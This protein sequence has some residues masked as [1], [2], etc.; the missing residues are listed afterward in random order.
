MVTW[1]IPGAHLIPLHSMALLQ[2]SVVNGM[3]PLP[4]RQGDTESKKTK[5]FAAGGARRL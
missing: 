1:R 2:N 3:L 5:L 4:P